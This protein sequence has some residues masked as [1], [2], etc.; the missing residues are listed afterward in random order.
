ASSSASSFVESVPSSLKNVLSGSSSSFDGSPNV[1]GPR[2]D[3]KS[4]TPPGGSTALEPMFNFRSLAAM[5]GDEEKGEGSSHLEHAPSSQDHKSDDLLDSS[6][7][8]S[9]A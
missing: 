5:I 9:N 3:G 1:H 2:P 8:N 6:P 4:S 7:A